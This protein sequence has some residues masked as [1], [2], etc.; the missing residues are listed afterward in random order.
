MELIVK[1]FGPIKKAQIQTKRYNVLIG[2]TSTGKSVIAKLISI[3]YDYEFLSIKDGDFSSFYSRLKEYEI[4]YAF[5][6]DTI[7]VIKWLGVTWDIQKEKF[8]INNPFYKPFFSQDISI[9][10]YLDFWK[11]I[12][13]HLIDHDKAIDKNNVDEELQLAI[14]KARDDFFARIRNGQMPKLEETTQFEKDY[15][16]YNFLASV[17][18]LYASVYIPAERNL[19]SIFIN[20]IFTL[21][22]SNYNI[23]ESVK[24]FGSLF[25]R[26]KG[27]NKQ[28]SLDFAKINIDFTDESHPITIA[29]EGTKIRF[30]QAS[31]GLQSLIPLWTVFLHGIHEYS[32]GTVI[33]EEPELNLFPTLQVDFLYN[34]ITQL[35]QTDANLLLTTHSPYILSVLDNLI[36]ASDVYKKAKD[37]NAVELIKR[38]EDTIPPIMMIHYEDV[39]AYHCKDDGEVCLMNDD[40][41]RNTGAYALDSASSFNSHIFNQLIEIDN[42]L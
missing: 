8:S 34:L 36:F 42:E 10:N 37:K 2:N 41:M 11:E 17:Y 39:A 26:A 38:I 12:N 3:A 35:N 21:L 30:E 5:H 16:F 40:E 31:S 14:E 27:E 9:S 4:D 1:N 23:P 15:I 13:Q 32:Y 22:K 28:L 7:I 20:N 33:I 6:E 29:N 19:M 18:S 24:R 25:E